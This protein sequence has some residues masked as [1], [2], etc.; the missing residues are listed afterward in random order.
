MTR[1]IVFDVDGVLVHGYHARPDLRDRWD[2][3]L[4]GI[5]INPDRFQREF[6]FDIL[7]SVC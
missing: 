4:L 3:A 6:I 2:E 1:A 7:S 5:G